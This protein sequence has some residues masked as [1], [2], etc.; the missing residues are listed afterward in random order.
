MRGRPPSS[1]PPSS[2]PRRPPLQERRHCGRERGRC[3][4]V[5]DAVDRARAERTWPPR[6]PARSTLTVSPLPLAFIRPR[7]SPSR[8]RPATASP[9]TPRTPRQTLL[10]VPDSPPPCAHHQYPLLS[11]PQRV[12]HRAYRVQRGL[13]RWWVSR[14]TYVIDERGIV[15][16]V[17]HYQRHQRLS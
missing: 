7:P 10:S 11:D 6:S 3:L 8:A 17:R 13:F 2:P 15:R 12:A 4:E 9:P 16:Y 14:M 5:E 1:S